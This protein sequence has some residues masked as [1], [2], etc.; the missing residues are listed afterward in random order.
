MVS[1]AW[2]G[3]FV[4]N[5]HPIGCSKTEIQE[6]F[7]ETWHVHIVICLAGQELK[8][9]SKVAVITPL[10]SVHDTAGLLLSWEGSVSALL[11]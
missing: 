2:G 8:K 9:S 10:Q 5:Q 4:I 7:G 1:K 11:W 3:S 6:P